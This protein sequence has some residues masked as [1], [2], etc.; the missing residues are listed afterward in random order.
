[1]NIYLV[2]QLLHGD[3]SEFLFY[4]KL[5]QSFADRLLRFKCTAVSFFLSHAI[6]ILSYI[7]P[8]ITLR[9]KRLLKKF[10]TGVLIDKRGSESVK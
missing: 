9:L 6:T 3:F 7:V 1:M 2:S 8:Y 4:Q 5:R 10:F